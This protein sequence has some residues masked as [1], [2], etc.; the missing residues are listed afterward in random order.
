MNTNVPK[1]QSLLLW[2]FPLWYLL[3]RNAQNSAQHLPLWKWVQ[4]LSFSADWVKGILQEQK[5]SLVHSEVNHELPQRVDRG[6]LCFVDGCT[7]RRPH[8]PGAAIVFQLNM[9]ILCCRAQACWSYTPVGA[10]AC[11]WPC[12][13]IVTRCFRYRLHLDNSK[14]LSGCCGYV[15]SYEVWTPSFG[16]APFQVWSP[17]SFYFEIL[18][19]S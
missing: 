13:Q 18:E 1:V 17:V 8:L 9:D 10:T 3:F 7:P 15:F 2:T 16:K 14:N 5:A 6:Q 12:P 19:F 4:F 11:D